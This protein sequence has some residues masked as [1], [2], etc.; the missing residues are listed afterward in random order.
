MFSSSGCYISVIKMTLL[1][2]MM[3][4]FQ[5]HAIIIT[6]LLL[7]RQNLSAMT[8]FILIACQQK[9]VTFFRSNLNFGLF[10]SWFSLL[11]HFSGSGLYLSARLQLCRIWQGSAIIS[12]LRT[13]WKLNIFRG[14]DFQN[15]HKCLAMYCFQLTEITS[16]QDV[17]TSVIK[18]FFS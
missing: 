15:K 5:H 1:H 16:S 17:I 8:S 6:Q 18:C 10:Q 7:F 3:T 14:P 13:D 11:K 12:T 9:P 2:W 4:S